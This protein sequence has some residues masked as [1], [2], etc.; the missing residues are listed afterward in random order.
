MPLDLRGVPMWGYRWVPLV[1]GGPLHGPWPQGRLGGG[2]APGHPG[3]RPTTVV[4]VAKSVVV[5][6]GVDGGVEGHELPLVRLIRPSPEE[7]VAATPQ[8]GPK[9]VHHHGLMTENN[10]V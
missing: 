2:W 3:A 8:L 10:E 6:G 4:V 5:V 7:F 1:P 9:R